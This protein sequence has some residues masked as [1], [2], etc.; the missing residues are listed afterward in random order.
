MPSP[1]SRLSC[2]TAVES[3]RSALSLRYHAPFPTYSYPPLLL[4]IALVA[5]EALAADFT[6]RVVGV[7]DGTPS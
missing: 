2:Q 5:S 6:G 4:S 1:L 3:G 7:A